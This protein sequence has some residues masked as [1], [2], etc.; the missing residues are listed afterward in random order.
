MRLDDTLANFS[1]YWPSLQRIALFLID[2]F[3]LYLPKYEELAKRLD[4]ALAEARS[5]R[6]CFALQY[7][8]PQDLQDHLQNRIQDTWGVVYEQYT[9]GQPH[10]VAVRAD[11][12]LNI[13][14][15]LLKEGTDGPSPS[16][17]LAA[18]EKYGQPQP[19]PGM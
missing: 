9:A 1:H 3:A 19:M 5:G 7:V 12:I 17:A 11:D 15:L 6:C 10:R 16:A 8:L 14:G 2:A 13:K 18:Q 4:A